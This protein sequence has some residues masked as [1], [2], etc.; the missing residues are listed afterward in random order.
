MRKDYSH[1]TIVLDRSGSMDSCRTDMEGGLRTFVEEQKKVDGK[2]TVSYYTFDS[3]FETIF[4]MMDINEIE[5][6]D[7]V[8]NPRG[9]TALIDGMANAINKTGASL[10][11]LKESERPNLVTVMTITD[12]GE[13]S[14][15]EFTNE[16][17]KAMVEEQTNK[18]SWDFNYLGANQDSF[19]VASSFG[20]SAS[21]VSNF[22]ET[23]T[24]A[25][26]SAHAGKFALARSM[27]SKGLEA[28]QCYDALNYDEKDHEE[29]NK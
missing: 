28:A 5:P 26:F 29:L 6:S 27:S 2:C 18:Y 10:R 17:L 25:L 19:G 11:A 3:V 20:I 16:Q 9:A 22:T 13:N 8:L 14:S 21:K 15:R 7:L 12:G 4:E 24:S 1:I 23:N